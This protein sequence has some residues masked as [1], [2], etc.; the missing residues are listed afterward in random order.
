MTPQVSSKR[1]HLQVEVMEPVWGLSIQDSYAAVPVGENKLFVATIQTGKPVRFVWTF[2]LHH[3]YQVTRIGK[4]VRSATYSLT[5]AQTGGWGGVTSFWI[6]VTEHREIQQ[7]NL[8]NLR[9]RRTAT[10]DP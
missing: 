2:D 6:N 5:T 7:I 3:L 9:Q 1:R 4:E 10:H 8:C